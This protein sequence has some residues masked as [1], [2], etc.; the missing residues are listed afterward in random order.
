MSNCNNCGMCCHTTI[1][2]KI[3]SCQ[4][5]KDIGND[6][7][8]CTRYNRRLGTIMAINKKTKKL[9]R[10]NLR[11]NAEWDYPGCPSNTGLPCFIEHCK[12]VMKK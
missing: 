6:K 3:T 1:T 7:S 8:T 11:K 9:A 5:L 10:C 12:E 4:Y 2:G